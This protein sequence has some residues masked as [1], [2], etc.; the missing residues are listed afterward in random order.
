MKGVLMLADR[1]TDFL[2]AVFGE[3][4]EHIRATDEKKVLISGSFIAFMGVVVAIIIDKTTTSWI[5]LVFSLFMLLVGS[6]VFAI[7]L[8]YRM[9]K[10]HY[11]EICYNIA[12]KFSLEEKFLP[13]WLRIHKVKRKF[14]ADNLLILITML[15][16]VGTLS[17]SLYLFWNI[18]DIAIILK[19]LYSNG[20]LI[21]YFSILIKASLSLIHTNLGAQVKSGKSK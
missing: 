13:V 1:E 14:S 12:S 20:F 6:C 4:N 3:T 5:Y 9:W 17:Y 16:N 15:M 2:F 11:L 7:Q 19:I 21:S 18:A 8:W 10:R